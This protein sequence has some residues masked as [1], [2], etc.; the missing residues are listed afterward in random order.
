M[1]ESN[2]NQ[3]I[4]NLTQQMNESNTEHKAAMEKL[5]SAID[6]KFAAQERIDKILRF[7][8]AVLL[9]IVWVRIAIDFFG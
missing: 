3:Q 9:V 7:E 4:S 2:P 6:E 5:L 8:F 1:T